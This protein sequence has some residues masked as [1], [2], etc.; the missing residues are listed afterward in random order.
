MDSSTIT[1]LACAVLLGLLLLR[2]HV[3]LALASAGFLGII[4]LGTSATPSAVIQA[5]PFTTTS[6]FSWT[7]V[8]MFVLMGILA[9]SSGLVSSL[10]GIAN[11]ILGRLPGGVGLATVAGCAGFSAVSGSSVATAAT[12]GPI[13]GTEMHRA[14]Y[15]PSFAAGLIASAGTLGVL[16]PPS[17]VLVMYGIVTGEPI[18]TLLIAGLVPGLISAVVL[19]LLVVTLRLVRP[20]TVMTDEA[21]A[22]RR[23]PVAATVAAEPSTGSVGESGVPDPGTSPAVDGPD[24]AAHGGGDLPIAIEHSA[25]GAILRLGLLFFVV[26]GGIYLGFVTA[27]EAAALGALTALIIALVDLLPHGLRAT[28]RT[29]AHA[30]RETASTTGM[31]FLIVVGSSIFTYFFVLAGVPAQ[32]AGWVLGFDARPL[33]IVALILLVMVPL[34]MFLEPI[35]MILIVVPLAYPIVVDELGFSGIW[36]AILAVKMIELSLITPPIGLNVFVVSAVMKN[37]VTTVEAFKG[38]AWFVL[39]DLCLIALFFF[40]PDLVLAWLPSEAVH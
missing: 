5:V 29:I 2:V 31:L 22:A 21:L 9:T 33:V 16:I 13:A 26:V 40:F 8:P 34:G 37:L 14:G 15:R 4:L 30:F 39:A 17:I 32:V 11:R 19:G 36:F 3:S 20:R 23:E 7:V 1:V 6:S 10:F 18:G 38:V 12:I 35:S 25:V 27:T 24:A 28:A